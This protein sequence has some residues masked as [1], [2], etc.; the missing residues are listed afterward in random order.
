MHKFLLKIKVKYY[1]VT[2]YRYWE[3]WSAKIFYIPIVFYYL[4]LSIKYRIS[5][6]AIS[7]V[8]P[9]FAFGG[10]AFDSKFDMISKFFHFSEYIAKTI[11]VPDSNGR[12]LQ[13]IQKEIL[14]NNIHFPFICKPDRG[15]RGNG[16]KIIRTEENLVSYMEVC[17]SAF[18]IQEYIDY[19]DR[20]SVV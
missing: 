19:P 18:L 13:T 16:F 4:L 20:K 11:F 3:F 9:C 15:H 6:T 5:L 12:D 1:Q 8:N 14:A 2:S 17:Q 10:M 7:A